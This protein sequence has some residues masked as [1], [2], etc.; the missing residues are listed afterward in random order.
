MSFVS[1][2]KENSDS[3]DLYYEDLR[4]SFKGFHF[5]MK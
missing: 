3:I 5:E 4:H 1:V 2:G